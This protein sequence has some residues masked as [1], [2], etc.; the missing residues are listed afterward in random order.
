MNDHV[1]RK[2]WKRRK[3]IRTWGMGILAG[4]FLVGGGLNCISHKHTPVEIQV[5]TRYL[6]MNFESGSPSLGSLSL[7]DLKIE[8]LSEIEFSKP[9]GKSTEIIKPDSGDSGFLNIKGDPENPV[10]DIDLESVPGE[11]S[12]E[13]ECL[14]RP[15]HLQL[16]ATCKDPKVRIPD[17]YLALPPKVKANFGG[18]SV[19]SVFVGQ[20]GPW[21]RVR[22]LGNQLVVLGESAYDSVMS[23][24]TET[25]ANRVS[26]SKPDLV[27]E[28]VKATGWS[29]KI[30]DGTLY[31]DALDGFK[32]ELR[33]GEQLEFGDNS[34]FE[35]LD[36]SIK[37]NH[38]SLV[39]S[40]KT[41]GLK[42]GAN[43]YPRELNPNLLTWWS[44]T[45]GFRLLWPLMIGLLI[46][47]VEFLLGKS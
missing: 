39:L 12:I 13:L 22:P 5:R 14:D 44:H 6:K 43:R 20:S 4:V 28:R 37:K 30:V 46:I 36:L 17:L 41:N 11:L 40:A 29:N 23:L 16:K 24:L 21:C 25:K 15:G 1:R 33:R 34:E 10:I 35:I 9:V 47:L 18:K 2:V 42:V 32:Y 19:D 8:P 31:I 45:N 26:F 27:F 38:M 3:T 7:K